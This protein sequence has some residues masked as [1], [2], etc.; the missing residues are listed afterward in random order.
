MINP[1]LRFG[2]Y[3]GHFYV[4]K[5]TPERTAT[6][7]ENF[8]TDFEAPDLQTFSPNRRLQHP[9]IE[10]NAKKGLTLGWHHFEDLETAPAAQRFPQIF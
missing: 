1:S 9:F 5:A 7:N 10:V 2:P 3:N 6:M 4:N 8:N